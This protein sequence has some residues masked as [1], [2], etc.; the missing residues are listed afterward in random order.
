MET[1]SHPQNETLTRGR[2]ESIVIQVAPNYE[3]EKIKEMEMFGWDMHGRQEIH[4]QGDAYGRPS[5]LD[6]STYL[7][8]TKVSS[9]VKLHFIRQLSL[10]NID[11]IKQIESEYFDVSFP[12]LPSTASYILPTI[13]ILVGLMLVLD[14]GAPGLVALLLLGGGGG[15]LFYSNIK[16]RNKNLKLCAQG[17]AKQ[18]EIIT[19]L[20]PFI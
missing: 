11:K 3:N 6:N 8:K 7:I 14:S 10:P 1:T 9:Y 20:Q 5:Y 2:T 4:Q 15:Y 17:A 16:T 18:A 19:K 12:A 13:L